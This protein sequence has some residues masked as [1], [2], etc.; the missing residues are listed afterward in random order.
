MKVNTQHEAEHVLEAKSKLINRP[1]TSKGKHYD[2]VFVYIPTD[3]AKD[4]AFPFKY[5]D[6]VVIR[7]DQKDKRLIIE[8][9]GEPEHEAREDSGRKAS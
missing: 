3:V 5:D 4:S 9:S 1:R 8:K 7:I 2:A 6:E